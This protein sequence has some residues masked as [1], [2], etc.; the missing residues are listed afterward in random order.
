M[1]QFS[2]RSSASFRRDQPPFQPRKTGFTLIELLVVIAIIAILAALLLPA[3]ASA[4]ERARRISC[5]NNLRQIALAIN[6]YSSDNTDYM[7]PLKMNYAGNNDY[8]YLMFEYSPQNVSPPTFTDGPYNLGTLWNNKSIPTGKPFYC[9]SVMTTGS[10]FTYDYYASATVAWPCG[11]NLASSPSNPSWVRAGYSYYPQSRQTGPVAT[12]S[13]GTKT[14]PDWPHYN[15][16]GN[17]SVLSSQK[18]VP[19]FKQS[20]IDQTKSMVVDLIHGTLNDLSHKNGG[21][22]GG[23]NAAFGDG[24]V[25]WQSIHANTLKYGFD[26]NVWLEINADSIPD[27]QLAMSAWQP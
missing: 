26:P 6:I 17:P 13:Y 10:T 1:K 24:H 23:L 3:L 15:A 16:P 5:V 4:K 8:M 18:I 14:L 11:I 2:H 25:A 21:T 7:P 27:F 9:P 20:A 19:L 12:Q 22:P